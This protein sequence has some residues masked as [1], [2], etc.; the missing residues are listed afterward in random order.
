MALAE[1][2]AVW[3]APRDCIDRR[4]RVRDHMFSLRVRPFNPTAST[5]SDR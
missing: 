5:T 1:A 2:S 4:L 3:D